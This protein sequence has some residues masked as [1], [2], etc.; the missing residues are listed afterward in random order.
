[1]NISETRG[2]FRI[3]CVAMPNPASKVVDAGSIGDRRPSLSVLDLRR[4]LRLP[5]LMASCIAALA[6]TLP[7]LGAAES[8]APIALRDVPL[9]FVDDTPI[10]TQ[11]GVVRTFHPAR[12]RSEPV[13]QPDR[14]WEGDRVYTYGSVY[15]D[16]ESRLFRLWY[17]SRS[18]RPD[19]TKPAPQL[20]GGGQDVVVYATSTD[21]VRWDKPALGLHAYDGSTAN[22]IVFD[23]H[24]PAVVLD[25]FERNAG[26]RYK[27]LG[28]FHGDYIAAYSADGLRWTPY[29]KTSVF[30]GNDTMSMTQD[31]RT[32]EFLAYFKKSATNV[33]GRVVWLTRSRDMQ[34]WSE[35]KLVFHSDEEDNRW[36]T[37]KEQNMEVYNMAVYPHAGGFFGL[38]T[39]FRVMGRVPKGV[40]MP[41]SQSGNDGPIDVQ[42]A[43]SSDGEKW[44]RTWPREHMIPRGAPGTFDG[45]TILGLTSTS[46][47]AGDETWI[48]YTAINT[49]HGGA[50]PPKRITIGRAEW[51]RHGFASLDASAAGGK[52][53][54]RPLIV[55]GGTLLIN[56]DASRGVLRAALREADGR[57]I[58]GF[59]FDDFEPLKS[60]ATRA[61]ARWK[62]GAVPG[63]R[64]VR[65]SIEMTSARLFSL[66]AT[67]PSAG[68]R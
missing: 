68:G 48:Y 42:M 60:N 59:S 49:G 21:G 6:L 43:T 19:G 63:D 8:E 35:P 38:P 24:S 39:M 31:P 61:V 64:P 25:R 9:L 47:D 46:V 37:R 45:G 50:I 5:P 65:V 17:M 57:P 34:T 62:G 55:S 15:Y 1:M 66:A 56:A 23:V 41:P 27:L 20:R 33:P 30:K 32:G 3:T 16:A 53:E 28:Y 18:Q 52:F 7:Q 22:N 2:A 36:S 26:K 29:P 67:L 58:A 44:Q 51:R 13:I 11:S 12:T 54:T 14:P 40:K 4:Q 10:A